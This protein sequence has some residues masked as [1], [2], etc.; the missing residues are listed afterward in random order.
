MWSLSSAAGA[1]SPPCPGSAYDGLLCE[2]AQASTWD[3]L[4]RLNRPLVLDL[5]TPERFAAGA[6][7]LGIEDRRAWLASTQGI[8]QVDLATLGPLWSGNYRYLWRPPRGF[9][10]PLARG[11]RG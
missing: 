3:V 11:D 8:E 5:V 7:L 6:L 1:P 10:R 9:T 2:L 4:S